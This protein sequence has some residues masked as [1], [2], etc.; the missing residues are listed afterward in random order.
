MKLEG[1]IRRLVLIVMILRD[2]LRIPL[3][4]IFQI[5]ILQLM[6]FFHLWYLVGVMPFDKKEL[7]QF[8]IYNNSIF[9]MVIM[10]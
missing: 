3:L 7:N 6:A 10:C 9:Y 8:E 4:P 5:Q 2:D 1:T